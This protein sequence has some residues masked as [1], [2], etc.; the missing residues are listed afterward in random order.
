MSRYPRFSSSS[1]TQRCRVWITLAP[2]G[3]KMG[4]PWPMTSTVVKNSSSR[5]SLLWSRFRASS[6]RRRYSSSSSFFGEGDAVDPLEHFPVGVA[7]P[8][9]AAALGQLEGVALILPVES[10]WGA[11]AQVGELALGVE[12]DDGVLGQVLNK[13]HF[14]GARFS[15]PCKQWPLGG[16]SRCAQVQPLLQ[17]FFISA[18]I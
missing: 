8:V 17:I 5:P 3:S 4:R 14:V 18:S 1:S 16:A 10:R 7:P 6:C 13:L 15:P 12:G 9:G 2:L 11:G